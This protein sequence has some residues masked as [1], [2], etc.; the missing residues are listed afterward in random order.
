M[1]C[2]RLVLA[3]FENHSMIHLEKRFL[4][5]SERSL[6]LAKR[7]LQNLI[8]LGMTGDEW[9]EDRQK[10]RYESWIDFQVNETIFN[11]S[12]AYYQIYDEGSSTSPGEKPQLLEKLENWKKNVVVAQGTRMRHVLPAFIDRHFAD[13]ISTQGCHGVT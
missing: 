11:A 5:D 6:D 3:W 8:F 4:S 1:H 7:K 2:R 10:F 12:V 13:T 9:D